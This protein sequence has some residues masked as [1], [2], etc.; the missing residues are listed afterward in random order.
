MNILENFGLLSTI[1]C[2]AFS[3]DSQEQFFYIF[4]RRN[5]ALLTTFSGVDHELFNGLNCM[6]RAPIPCKRIQRVHTFVNR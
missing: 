3:L 1:D 2:A 5:K 6:H 4:H